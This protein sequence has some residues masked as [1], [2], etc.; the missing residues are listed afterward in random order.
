[1]TGWVDGVLVNEGDQG[2]QDVGRRGDGFKFLDGIC[3]GK[4]RIS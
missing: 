2:A 1:M 3:G 4:G